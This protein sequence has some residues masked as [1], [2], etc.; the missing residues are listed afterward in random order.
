LH[1]LCFPDRRTPTRLDPELVVDRPRD[2]I[3]SGFLCIDG[4]LVTLCSTGAFHRSPITRGH[5]VSRI[6]GHRERVSCAGTFVVAL[7]PSD[8]SLGRSRPMSHCQ[9]LV[10]KPRP[11]E[12]LVCLGV[13]G[14]ALGSEHAVQTARWKSNITSP[15]LGRAPSTL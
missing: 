1:R 8:L 14:G 11:R 7:Q 5:W 6:I 10:P 15:L 3:E 13:V 2:R 9:D 12:E 4:V